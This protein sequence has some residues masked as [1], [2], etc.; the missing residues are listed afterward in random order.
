MITWAVTYWP[1]HGT[2]ALDA[3]IIT[4]N[5]CDW[6]ELPTEGVLMVLLHRDGY[7]HRLRYF[8]HYWLDPASGRHGG[9]Y[10][11]LTTAHETWESDWSQAVEGWDPPEA[12]HVISGVMVPDDVWE[13][14]VP[15]G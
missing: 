12:V 10:G 14:L 3:Y 1:E 8:D 2:S 7:T 6:H 5:D 13:A 9:W 15:D 11:T 4:S